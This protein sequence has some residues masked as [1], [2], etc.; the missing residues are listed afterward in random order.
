M[1]LGN[2]FQYTL[3]VLLKRRAFAASTAG[4]IAIVVFASLCIFLALYGTLFRRLPFQN[5]DRLVMLWESD[6]ETGEQRLPLMEGS[7][8]FY[9]EA[10][11]RSF[12][13]I[14]AFQLIDD[15][16]LPPIVVAD[17]GES[18][19]GVGADWKLF[20]ALGASPLLGRLFSAEESRFRAPGVAILSYEFWHRRFGG[21]PGVIGQKLTLNES[22][23]LRPYTVVGVMPR[24][25]TFPYPLFPEKPDLWMSAQYVQGRFSFHHLDVIGKL[26]PGATLEKAQ[27]EL[28]QA[29]KAIALAQPRRYGR[30][31]VHAV[32]V[33]A[34]SLR[35]AREIGAALV[36]ALAFVTLIGCANTVHLVLASATR[37]R[38]EVAV[39]LAL[40]ATGRDIFRATILEVSVLATVGGVAGVGLAFWGAK[41][42][43]L[44]LPPQLY[45]PPI[46]SLIFDAPVVAFAA[47][48]CLAVATVLAVGLRFPIRQEGVLQHLKGGDSVWKSRG[49]LARS[50]S[51]L[52]IAEVACAFALT[53]GALVM[54]Q[55]LE[56]LM[57]DAGTANAEQL[58]ALDVFFPRNGTAPDSSAALIAG[59]GDVLHTAGSLPGVGSV[60]LADRFPLPEAFSEFTARGATGAIGRNSQ[61][62]EI[63]IVSSGFLDVVGMHVLEGRWLDSS[64]RSPAGSESVAV[65]NEAFARRYLLGEYAMGLRLRWTDV[66]SAPDH[67]NEWRIVGIVREPPRFG[68]GREAPPAV[69]LPFAQ[70]PLQDLSVVL[71]TNG[72]ARNLAGPMRNA[73]LAAFLGTVSVRRLRTGSEIVSDAAERLRFAS[74][75]LTAISLVALVLAGVGIYGIISFYT[76]QRTREIAVRMAVGSTAGQVVSLVVRRAMLLVGVGAGIGSLLALG[77]LRVL[78]SLQHRATPLDLLMYLV[79][80]ALLCAVGAVA[81]LLPARRAAS[82]DPIEVLR[83]E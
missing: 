49:P 64:D 58:L 72:P 50:G 80:A 9:R 41:A 39:R 35:N 34:E 59:Y 52:L 74:V 17:T 57:A 63:H 77:L 61:P 42:L 24:G 8:Q 46:E 78:R 28:T 40:G 66:A 47:I 1:T 5:V 73:V 19:S 55:S 83:E 30:V 29:A 6:Q 10:V 67:P 69:Y 16:T 14:G 53:A 65:I 68:S 26:N 3:R 48:F 37:R 32:P 31:T 21:R 36:A 51:V 13:T 33:R 11:S 45:I 54:F 76:S 75:Q 82:V 79:A 4:T 22:G 56:R 71:R 15:P 44:L 70:Y 60:A 18:V 20:Q 81:S 62:A 43:R 7:Y 2:D 12:E 25:F 27:A 38:R 23:S